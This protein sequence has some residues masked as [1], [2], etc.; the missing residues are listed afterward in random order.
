MFLGAIAI[1]IITAEGDE[2]A[3][4]RA[5]EDF[6]SFASPRDWVLEDSGFYPDGRSYFEY[7]YY[8]E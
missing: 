2:T 7:L 8:P 3:E 6:S 1:T 5:F 4:A